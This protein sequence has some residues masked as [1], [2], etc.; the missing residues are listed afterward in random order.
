ME[1][2]TGPN[3]N[4]QYHVCKQLHLQAVQLQH[5]QQLQHRQLQLQEKQQV[6]G[7][8]NTILYLLIR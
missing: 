4:K 7:E 8:C 3:R 2:A 5:Q 1:R 6:Q